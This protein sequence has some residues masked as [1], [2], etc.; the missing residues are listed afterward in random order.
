MS[1]PRNFIY[2]HL[3]RWCGGF[4]D[5]EIKA[6]ADLFAPEVKRLIEAAY[7]Q[8]LSDGHTN[9]EASITRLGAVVVGVDWPAL[10]F[11]EETP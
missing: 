4:T 8:G 3:V 11:R 7:D 10:L 2:E 6:H 1:D 9:A 5:T